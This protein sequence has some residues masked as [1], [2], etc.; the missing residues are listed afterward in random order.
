MSHEALTL[1]ILLRFNYFSLVYFKYKNFL[2]KENVVE[3]PK[4]KMCPN[5]RSFANKL[6]VPVPFTLN[7]ICL[8]SL[9]H[10]MRIKIP[11]FRVVVRVRNEKAKTPST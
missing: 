2:N 5:F 11:T 8:S 10:K 4:R 1:G 6:C 3:N 9:I 7:S